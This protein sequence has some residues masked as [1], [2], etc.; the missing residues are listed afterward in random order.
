[1]PRLSLILTGTASRASCEAGVLDELLYVLERLNRGRTGEDRYRIDGI[2]GASA[3]ALTGALVAQAVMRGLDRRRFLHETWVEQVDILRLLQRAP[4]NAL[5]SGAAMAQVAE[6]LLP[7]GPATP[8]S[9]LAADSLRMSFT[10]T[11]LTGVDH[12]L[13]RRSGL[14]DP[15][16]FTGTFHA[17]RRDFELVP[18][19]PSADRWE[20][21]RETA[22]ASG[23]LPI[24]FP[25][26]PLPSDVE[27]WPGHALDPFPDQFWYVDGGVSGHEPVGEAARLARL[28]DD[29]IGGT[30]IDPGRRFLLVDASLGRSTHDPSASDRTP[31]LETARRLAAAST[32]NPTARDWMRAL[33][34]NDEVEGRD[35]MVGAL[36]ELVR[37]LSLDRADP[38]LDRVGSAADEV[39]EK[40]RRPREGGRSRREH[41]QAAVR[42]L[43]DRHAETAAGLGPVHR[44]LFGELVFLVNAAGLD[45][46]QKL[47]L[48]MIHADPSRLASERLHGFAGLLEREWRQHDYTVGRATGRADLPGILGLSD[49]ELPEPEPGV[50]YEPRVDVG[51]VTM[52]RA[53]RESREALRAT[54]L[55]GVDAATQ[56]L[57]AGPAG[58]RWAVGPLARF[59]L[60]QTARARID[61]ALSL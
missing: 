34:R 60:R 42:R 21:I 10:L 14:E 35:A 29:P 6:N 4:S 24:A 59:A 39:V 5:L 48:A 61:S 20:E 57:T 53:P 36:A 9:T 55:R 25:P 27:R 30:G 26:H 1:M 40:G 44:E 52:D 31:L 58:L 17:E 23:S 12:R 45:R 11:N 51:A 38:L 3:G 18:D 33:R 56:S 16:T 43:L 28:T 49:A 22:L 47:D 37:R 46:T 8:P 32:G 19:D 15:G 54:L 7:S 50:P 13:P 2:V 41:R